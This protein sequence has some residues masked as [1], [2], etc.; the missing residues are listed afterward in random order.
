MGI[1]NSC[2]SLCKGGQGD[3]SVVYGPDQDVS[4]GTSPPQWM[5]GFVSSF[6]KL[7]EWCEESR[8]ILRALAA[9]R[10]HLDLLPEIKTQCDLLKVDSVFIRGKL[11]AGVGGPSP[12]ARA[13][14]RAATA[15]IMKELGDLMKGLQSINGDTRS[16]SCLRRPVVKF[17]AQMGWR[18][19]YTILRPALRAS[20][21]SHR[22][23]RRS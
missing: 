3:G 20:R 15:G 7:A 8:K 21:I 14:D 16:N 17:T 10:P 9:K 23:C 13:E 6:E 5:Q 1:W 2:K 18:L 19:L 11:D 4:G 12:Q 22:L